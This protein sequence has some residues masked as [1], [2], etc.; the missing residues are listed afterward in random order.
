M[1]A[2]NISKLLRITFYKKVKI[3]KPN[4]KALK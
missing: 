3:K 2:L 1:R 4:K